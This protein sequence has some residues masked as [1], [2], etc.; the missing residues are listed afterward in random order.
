HRLRKRN[1]QDF[2]IFRIKMNNNFQALR[3]IILLRPI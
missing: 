3:K 2:P 1:I